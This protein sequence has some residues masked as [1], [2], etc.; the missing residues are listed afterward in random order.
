MV[1][2]TEIKQYI[3]NTV[4]PKQNYY[5]YEIFSV[6]DIPNFTAILHSY[7]I[8][9]FCFISYPLLF[10]DPHL[11]QDSHPSGGKISDRVRT[12]ACILLICLMVLYISYV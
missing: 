5:Y 8:L 6:T 11:I 4:S 12:S 3:F 10:P 2:F 7:F 9:G 1:V